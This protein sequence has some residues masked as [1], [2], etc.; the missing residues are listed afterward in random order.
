MKRTTVLTGMLTV[1]IAALTQT[2]TARQAEDYL[3]EGRSYL[4]DGTVN[5][6][7]LAYDTFDEG[8][9]DPQCEGNDQLRFFRAVSG[10]IMLVMEDDGGRASSVWELARQYGAR[11]SLNYWGPLLEDDFSIAIVHN[12]RGV[13]EIPDQA[14]D[15]IE[16]G[17]LMDESFIPRIDQIMA[18]LDSITDAPGERFR[19]YIEPEERRVVFSGDSSARGGMSELSWALP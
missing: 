18:D 9:K 15:L 16:L 6:L 17:R 19:D 13:Y 10:T 11:L 1:L 3:A 2:A 5:G 7:Q 14:P 4:F 12:E 8:V